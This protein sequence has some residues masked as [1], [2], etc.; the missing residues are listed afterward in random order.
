VITGLE[1]H[2]VEYQRFTQLQ[3]ELMNDLLRKAVEELDQE[4][5]SMKSR[6]FSPAR[7]SGLS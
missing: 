5:P 7:P 3:T 4:D 2:E 6:D 1:A